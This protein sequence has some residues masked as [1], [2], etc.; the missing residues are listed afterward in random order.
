M[1]FDIIMILVKNIQPFQCTVFCHIGSFEVN[2]CTRKAYARPNFLI[3]I[4]LQVFM[5]AYCAIVTIILK[6]KY[7]DNPETI[8]IMIYIM[9]ENIIL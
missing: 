9:K 2:F 8:M 1:I 3:L 5:Y 6:L 4:L 7:I